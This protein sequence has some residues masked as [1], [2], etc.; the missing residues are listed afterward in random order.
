[1]ER[2]QLTTLATQN[3]S[4]ALLLATYTADADREILIQLYLSGLA[5]SG[6]YRACLTK[7]LAGAGAAYQSP[8]SAIT[9]AATVTTAFM[10][11]IV[12]PVK[13]SD[14]VK[15][16]AQGLAGDTSVAA[17]I[18]V[19]D[20]VSTL[21]TATELALVKG[22]VDD[23]GVAGAGLSAIPW[24]AAWD[25]EVE[26]EANDALVAY[27]PPT[28]AELDAGNTATLAAIA[29]IGSGTGAALNFAVDADNSAAPLNGVTK[30]GTA[31]G[32][33]ANTLANDAS[34]HAL[35]SA[36]DGGTQKILWVYG[37]TVG[38]GRS[39]VKVIIRAAMAAVG[40][41]V[42]FKLYNFGTST[43]D[44][45]TTITGTASQ[46]LDI[47]A[48]A[49]H[50]GTGTNAGK[51]YLQI[52]FD[53][54]DAGTINVNECYCQAQNLGLTVG[55]ADGAIWVGGANANATPYVDGTADN[56][57]TWAAAKTLAAAIG[58]TRFRIR[59]GTTITLDAATEN[60]S[61]IG[62]NWTLA[63]GSQSISG[64]YIEGAQ[65][66]TGISS[67]ASA[68]TFN[69]CRFGAATV[70][71]AVL[72]RCGMGIAGA[73]FTAAAKGTF[74]F[75][76]C[77][78]LGGGV[79]PPVF[80]FAG[81]GASSSINF[82]RWDGGATMTFDSDCTAA[83]NVVS[84]G[85][86]TITSGGAVVKLRGV[87]EE[88]A[89]V[90]SAGSAVEIVGV[91]GSIA[92]SGA[93]GTL[94]ITGVSGTVTDTSDPATTITQTQVNRAA[95]NAEVDTALNTA[96]PGSPTADSINERVATMDTGVTLTSAAVDAILDDAIEGSLTMRQ[97]L[98]IFLA[99][100]A[101]KSNGGGTATI[102]FRNLADDGDRIT[103][104]VDA[105]GNRSAITLSGT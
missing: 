13:A 104:T 58:L 105:G 69:D 20:T 86:Q 9:L 24:N 47:P 64:S 68:P 85:A 54:A 87:F 38:A 75:T 56:P 44:T 84:G 88:I 6:S 101:G 36:A 66:V 100:L 50:T 2:L 17:K 1:M 8:S 67:G 52:V 72:L 3:I 15:V 61:L 51:V 79:T 22:Y 19:F 102:K 29:G 97:A 40:D 57:V 77:Y 21:A 98:R 71:P 30:L 93:S 65:Q 82:R 63:L 59:N 28:F 99:A 27:D 90:M 39:A 37:F 80:A 4:S 74:T 32:T 31:T 83:V 34:V 33:F 94:E 25:T 11:A 70:P 14:V 92:V 89:L 12:L 45:R 23:I 81:L 41:T 43:W 53:E 10:P 78:S 35:A 16:Y 91:V 18:E 26:S 46:L 60:K 62:R 5:G 49:G 95:I 76:D 103:A 42:T 73:T 55:Y 96:I 7:Q 48:L